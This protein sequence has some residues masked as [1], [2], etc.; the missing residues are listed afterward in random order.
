MFPK[1]RQ[2]GNSTSNFLPHYNHPTFYRERAYQ[3]LPNDGRPYFTAATCSTLPNLH[4]L[5]LYSAIPNS[6][7]IVFV[8]I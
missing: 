4:H 8:Q 3:I 1:E 7:D 6:N 2:K 5:I